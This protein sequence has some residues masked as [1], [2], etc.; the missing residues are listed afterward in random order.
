MFEQTVWL[1]E[2]WSEISAKRRKLHKKVYYKHT[3]I[4]IS[5]QVYKSPYHKFYTSSATN[6]ATAPRGHIGRVCDAIPLGPPN[7]IRSG[8]GWP[9]SAAATYRVCVH[10]QNELG[11]DKILFATPQSPVIT[12]NFPTLHREHAASSRAPKKRTPAPF[13][14][15]QAKP[16]LLHT[17]D[18]ALKRARHT[19]TPSCSSK[20]QSGYWATVANT[21][22]ADG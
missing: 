8:F 12:W 5:S 14:G 9:P 17:H 6:Q 22:I 3:W 10:I 18:C 2:Q 20:A 15:S 16:S 19:N 11:Q 4:C 13:P 1:F 21:P 7:M